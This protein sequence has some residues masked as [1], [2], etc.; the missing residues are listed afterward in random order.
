[1]SA[2]DSPAQRVTIAVVSWN[3]REPLI[4]CLHSLWPDVES[5]RA[6]VVVVDNGST[7]GS[8]DA[9]REHAPWA[10][11]L[12]PGVNLG[13]GPAVNLAATR[14]D[15]QWL[16]CANADVALD[17]GALEA[18]LAAAAESSVGCVAPRLVLPDGSV[19]HSVYPLPTVP[20]TLAFN[21]GLHRLSR[22]LAD[23]LCLEGYWDPD[24]RRAVPWA[25]GA[26][27]LFRR[28]AFDAAGGFDERQWLYA[29]DLDLGWRL[30]DARWITRYEPAAVVRHRAGAATTQ[31]FGDGRVARFT[32]ETYAVILRR[33]GRP[34]TWVTVALNIGG[35]ATRVA[36]VAPLA[37][38]LPRWRAPL[39]RNRMWLHAHF[40]GVRVAL[41]S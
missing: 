13:F 29:E 19:Q 9:V 38:V 24:R 5:G 11:L 33:R 20:F 36:W 12:E 6:E 35:A 41:R 26:F 28:A 39:R 25:I 18:M 4:S 30:H 8:P 32:R 21:L 14:T 34:R 22:T 17:P 37:A 23:E 7:D 3:T 2:G 16:A 1:M 31:A 27:L 40:Q 15:G 10:T